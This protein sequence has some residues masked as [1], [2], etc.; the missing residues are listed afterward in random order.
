MREGRNGGTKEG[1]ERKIGEKE[2][3]KMIDT[4]E[5]AIEREGKKVNREIFPPCKFPVSRI[6]SKLLKNVPRSRNWK[7]KT[8]TDNVVKDNEENGTFRGSRYSSSTRLLFLQRCCSFCSSRRDGTEIQ[9]ILIERV[10]ASSIAR[11]RSVVVMSP[12]SIKSEGHESPFRGGTL[13]GIA[14]TVK[15]SIDILPKVLS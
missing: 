4:E 9:C 15:E 8:K 6:E 12:R 7:K 1:M 11:S 14:T 3:D 10:R 2:Y 13:S 5:R